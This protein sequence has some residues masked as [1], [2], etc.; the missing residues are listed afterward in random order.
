M[1][2]TR[3][4]D[5]LPL[6]AGGFKFILVAV[7]P[8]DGTPVPRWQIEEL[9][10]EN[11]ENVFIPFVAEKP[12][13]SGGQGQKVVAVPHTPETLVAATVPARAVTIQALWTNTDN[14]ALGM[15]NTTRS[16]PAGAEAG[17]VLQAGQSM[18]IGVRDLFSI[19]I[20]VEVA[21]EG[22]SYLYVL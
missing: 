9:V 2:D 16:G 4:D 13:I 6:D 1:A 21:G 5:H 14:I 7:N 19:W 20:D 18:V 8:A 11:S 3:I 10:T 17:V 12:G 15:T 22:V